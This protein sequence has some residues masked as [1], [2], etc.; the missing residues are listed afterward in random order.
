MNH[1]AV[2]IHFEIHD[3]AAEIP[4]GAKSEAHEIAGDGIDLAVRRAGGP[5]QSPVEGPV[6][7]GVERQR[8]EGYRRTV[9]AQREQYPV[10]DQHTGVGEIAIHA[11]D[12]RIIGPLVAIPTKQCTARG[13][14]RLETVGLYIARLQLHAP[15]P[16][17]EHGHHAIPIEG[18]VL[19]EQRRKLVI[20]RHP[21]ERAIDFARNLTVDLE[22][23]QIDF[24][25][26]RRI[27]AGK[28]RNVGKFHGVPVSLR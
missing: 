18:H 20:G 3:V 26:T 19:G 17:A 4:L 7:D 14:L 24:G 11:G 12:G 10:V 5:R 21:I 27:H 25:P 28:H 1:A 2:W 8:I 23:L 6:A 9:L 16:E 15:V 13:T 22:V